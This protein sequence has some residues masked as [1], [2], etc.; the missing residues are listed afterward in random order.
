M[1]YTITGQ[2]QV[3]GNSI[4]VT[5]NYTLNDGSVQ[6]GIVVAMFNPQSQQDIINNIIARGQSIQNEANSILAVTNLMNS[7]NLIGITGNI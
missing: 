5:V 4:N 2:E 7:L 3:G 1:T 6:N